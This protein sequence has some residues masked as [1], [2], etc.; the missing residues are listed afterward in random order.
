MKHIQASRELCDSIIIMIH[1]LTGKQRISANLNPRFS[2]GWPEMFDK[3]RT[4][5]VWTCIDEFF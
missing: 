2:F 4:V 1:S 5:K 3:Y